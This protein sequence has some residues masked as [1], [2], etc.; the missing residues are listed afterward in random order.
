MKNETKNS[1]QIILGAV[2]VAVFIFSSN[3][4]SA[5]SSSYTATL[6][7]GETGGVEEVCCNGVIVSFESVNTLNPNILDGEAIIIPGVSQIYDHGN[8]MSEGYCAL[9][10]V[11]P[12]G[13]CVT[14]ESECYS[15]EIMT[16]VISVG[17]SA[18]TCNII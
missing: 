11:T 2:L 3:N 15:V 5:Q 4:I 7:G 6:I 17:T 16:Q 18:G 1:I 9:G 13:V 8:E 12:Y 10:K 14:I